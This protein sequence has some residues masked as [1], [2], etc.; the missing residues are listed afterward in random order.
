MASARKRRFQ[1]GLRSLL[2]VV[3]LLALFT[4]WIGHLNRRAAE[5]T[6]L[7][8]ELV[9]RGILVDLE[10][11][12]WLGQ[13]VKKFAPRR[14]RWLRERLGGGWL[15]YPTVLCCWELREDHLPANL[16]RIKRLGTVREFH[17]RLE[18]SPQVAATMRRELPGI[19]VLTSNAAIRTYY[20]RRLTQPAFA[21]E[22]A[23]ILALLV[24][25]V[26]GVLAASL[27][28]LVKRRYDSV[29]ESSLGP[30]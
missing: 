7:T 10:E 13:L 21:F 26:I 5:R 30:H 16:E 12:N 9:S 19:D 8:A 27:W 1:F 20:Q 22:G 4:G 29:P 24:L 14:E 23:A 28:W 18:P 6:K 25:G 2:I 17:F 11:P 15:G 3:T